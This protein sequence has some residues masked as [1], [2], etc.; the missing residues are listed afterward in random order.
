MDGI[1]VWL[2]QHL[3][4]LGVSLSLAAAGLLWAFL[5]FPADDGSDEAQTVVVLGFLAMVACLVGSVSSGV[6]APWIPYLT[7]VALIPGIWGA[8]VGI[9]KLGPLMK[10]GWAFLKRKV[11]EEDKRRADQRAAELRVVRARAEAE[12]NSPKATIARCEAAVTTYLASLPKDLLYVDES[13]QAKTKLDALRGLYKLQADILKIGPRDEA[14][15][16][17]RVAQADALYPDVSLETECKDLIDELRRQSVTQA[18]A[19]TLLHAAIE[20]L[21]LILTSLP[22]KAAPRIAEQLPFEY[23]VSA[24]DL[25]AEYGKDVLPAIRDSDSLDVEPVVPLK[26][27]PGQLA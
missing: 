20:K 17:K 12:A 13:R 19:V 22:Y 3:P 9:S 4:S 14:S 8:G 21:T 6:W 10:R 7:G 11:A 5:W 15:F 18:P 2:L 27:S 1:F 16:K 26:R 25:R 24:D 23:R